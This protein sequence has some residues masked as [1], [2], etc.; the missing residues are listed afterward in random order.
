MDWL[1]QFWKLKSSKLCS[2]HCCQWCR[3]HSE[4]QQPWEQRG[5]G[6]LTQIQRLEKIN[7]PPQAMREENFLI[8]RHSAFLSRLGFYGVG[9]APPVSHEPALAPQLMHTCVLSQNTLT[10]T[11]RR[12]YEWTSR[13][14]TTQTNWHTKRTI[15]LTRDLSCKLDSLESFERA[16]CQICTL[17]QLNENGWLEC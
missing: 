8:T 4:S 11:S 12:V 2:E 16:R 10:D 3:T 15:T 6:G 9:C 5:A 7:V 13:Y 1:I 14:T 17:D